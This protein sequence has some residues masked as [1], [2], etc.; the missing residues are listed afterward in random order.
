MFDSDFWQEVIETIRRQKWRSL[1]TAF[2]VF[3]GLFMLMF[4][5]GAGMGFSG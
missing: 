1:M 4:L 5:I 2:G 3:W